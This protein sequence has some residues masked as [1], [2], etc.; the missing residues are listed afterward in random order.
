MDIRSDNEAVDLVVD[1]DG[2]L[3]ATDLLWESAFQL[4]KQNILY[5]FLLPL[6][7]SKGKGHL[8]HR[9]SLLVE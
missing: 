8:K 4:L 1:L 9:I 5:I 6:W 2:T 3:I 7:A